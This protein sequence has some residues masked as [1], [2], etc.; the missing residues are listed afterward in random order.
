VKGFSAVETA[1]LMT[2]VSAMT[3]VA[4]PAVDNYIAQ[5]RL[6][7][8][9][10]DTKVIAVA[11]VRLTHD[12]P[13]YERS[14]KDRGSVLLVGAGTTPQIGLGGDA[15]WTLE[16]SARSKVGM[17][18]DHLVTNGVRYSTK[19][20]VGGLGGWRGPYIDGGLGP[21]PWG[22]RYAASVRWLT[23]STP[24]DTVVLSAG[25]NGTVETPF[26]RDGVTPGGD[27]LLAIVSSGN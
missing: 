22:Q 2:A 15:Q 5:A 3:A 10:A 16:P 4:A 1:T 7:K 14:T 12:V 8:A 11:L 19:S 25:P 23:V 13:R 24:F 26:G 9:M 18:T 21:D 17:L 20:L 27:D 6:T